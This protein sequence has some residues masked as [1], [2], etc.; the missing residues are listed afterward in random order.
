MQT[1]TGGA[2]VWPAGPNLI[3]E[4]RGERKS[5]SMPAMKPPKRP[6]SI[7]AK[8]ASP[9][10][11]PAGTVSLMVPSAEVITPP[12]EP[13]TAPPL[14]LGL[15]ALVE[16]NGQTSQASPPSLPSELSWEGLYSAGQLSTP[17][18]T[19]S[20]SASAITLIVVRE[21]VPT[22]VATSTQVT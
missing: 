8:S 7:Q 5:V 22:L 10:M 9:V 12:A 1:L 13:M 11:V 15:Q 14:L 2:K 18:A 20:L 6:V 19:V 3:P 21:P 4:T 16:S 17:S